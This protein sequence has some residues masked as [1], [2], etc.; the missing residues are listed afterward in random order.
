MFKDTPEMDKYMKYNLTR[1]ERSYIAQF[2][3]GVLP[4]RIETGRFVREN[5]PNRLCVFCNKNCIEDEIHFLIHCTAYNDVR[6]LFLGE[7]INGINQYE[8]MSDKEKIVNI[9]N[10]N[11]RN[12]ARYIHSAFDK[13]KLLTND[14]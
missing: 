8:H 12:I 2:R 7:I 11:S 13:R 9:M 4:L 10:N 3:L 6:D 5:I 1:S 14:V